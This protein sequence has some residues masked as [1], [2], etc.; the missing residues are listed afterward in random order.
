MPEHKYSNKIGKDGYY[1]LGI[2]VGRF[3]D[4]TEVVVIKVSKLNTGKLLK[5]IVNIFTIEGENF[6]LQAREI[7]RI[8]NRFKCRAAVVDGNG[9]GAG[10]VD[11]LVTDDV[12]P[13]TDEPL[14][15]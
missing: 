11:Q 4:Q 15:G 10:L 14:Y 3:G 1:I 5:Q 2:D 8:F 9:L 7:K 13:T 6:I 12:D